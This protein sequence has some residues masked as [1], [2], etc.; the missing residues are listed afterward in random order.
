[1]HS[2]IL[3][4]AGAPLYVD[5]TWGHCGRATSVKAAFYTLTSS[6]TARFQTA[7]FG[8]QCS[9]NTYLFVSFTHV[10]S[11]LSNIADRSLP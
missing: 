2:T 5:R 6:F 8:P 1:M 11:S 3:H 7:I 9:H 10:Y 4:G